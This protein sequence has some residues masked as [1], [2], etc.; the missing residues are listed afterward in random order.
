[1]GARFFESE[2]DVEPFAGAEEV[3]ADFLD[4]FGGLLADFTDFF[5]TAEVELANVGD[6]LV[7]VEDRLFVAAEADLEG[8]ELLDFGEGVEVV[9]ESAVKMDRFGGLVGG[10]AVENVVGREQ[11]II[12]L[13]ADLAC[14]VAGGVVDFDVVE[15]VAVLQ[16]VLYGVGDVGA[17]DLVVHLAHLFAPF[18][19]ESGVGGEVEGATAV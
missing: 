10:G 16:D 18:A 1:M 4:R 17:S 15:G 5:E 11:N 14:A 12:D 9:A 8:G 6:P 19:G 7:D 2:P 13:V 3:A